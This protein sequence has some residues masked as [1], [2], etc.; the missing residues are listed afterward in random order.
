MQAGPQVPLVDSLWLVDRQASL[1]ALAL[2]EEQQPRLSRADI[3]RAQSMSALPGQRADQW[4]VGRVALRAIIERALTDSGSAALAD[5]LRRQAFDLTAHGEPSLS[6]APFTFSQSDAGSYLLIAIAGQG[7]VG[8]D[9][10][11]P[12]TVTMSEDRQSRV[13]AAARGLA[14][15]EA[16]EPVGLLQAWT[17][18]EAFAKARGPSLARV[19]TELGLIGVAGNMNAHS[20]AVA[21]A[22]EGGLVTHDLTLPHSLIGSIARPMGMPVPPLHLFVSSTT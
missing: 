12:R 1:A 20:R 2:M 7:R 4:R 8:V 13:M 16:D 15:H 10:E 3:E 11:Q 6:A 9:L 19:L 14:G 21:V 17:R 18:I 5:Q 22:R